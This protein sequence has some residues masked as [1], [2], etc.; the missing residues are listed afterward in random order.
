[1]THPYIANTDADRRAMLERIGVETADRLFDDI[2]AAFRRPALNL[3]PALSEPELMAELT[4]LAE[5]NVHA[6]GVPC[7]MGGGA[8]RHYV[9]SVVRHLT[10]RGEFATAYTPYQPEISQ[11]TLQAIFEFQS[12]VCELTGMDVANAGM[13]D[14]AEALAEACLMAVHVTGRRR[15]AL[16][17]TVNPLYRHTVLTFAAG[18]DLEVDVV[19]PGHVLLTEEHACLAVQQPNFFGY[20]EDL[21]GLSQAAHAAGALYVVGVDP[22]SLGLFR[23]P[24]DYDADIVVG[25]GQ[26]LGSPL[27]FGGPYLGLFACKERFLRQMPGRVVGRTTDVDG[28]TGYV[29]TLQAREQHIRRERATS[30]ICT[31]EAL[32][33]LAATVY[34][35]AVGRRG[36]RRVAELCYHKAHYAAERIAALPGYRLPLRGT[37]FKEFVVECPAPPAE[38]N[39]HLLRRGILGGVDVSDQVRNGLLLC[40]TELNSR[41]EIDRLAA[42]LGELGG[43][44]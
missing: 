41:D 34:L 38:V 43:A 44:P 5:R 27:N 16:L 24:G 40:V 32:V 36:L 10:G 25:E 7:F 20:L 33:A 19:E 17:S 42:A 35:T 28:R 18:Q 30:N 6:N 14:G 13:Y 2:P 8:Y 39:R 11:G 9:P 3:P 21:A 15:I 29:L 37:F 26:P 12:M 4:A 31:S 1:M 23:P 22:I